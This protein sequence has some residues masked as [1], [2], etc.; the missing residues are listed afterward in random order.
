MLK[1]EW[2]NKIYHG[3]CMRIMPKLPDGS[4][5]LILTDIPY[6]AVTQNGEERAK[7]GGQMRKLDKGLA[8]IETFELNEFLQQLYR[9]SK[10]SIYIFCGIEQMSTVFSFFNEKK[11]MTARQCIWHKTNPSPVNGQHY[12]IHSIENCVFAKKRK[13]TF[14]QHCKHN[15]WDFPVGRSK[16]HPTEKPLKLFEYI[17]ES[18]SN[19]EDTVFDP[20]SGSAT[21]AVASK[22]LNRKYICIEKDRRHYEDSLVRVENV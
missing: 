15:V 3:D 10:G 19:E 22:N 17:I 9:L 5:E 13:T 16:I 6:G 7:Y 20:C 4:M 8:D 2:K 12:W 14:N 18:S 1:E 21:T 11:D